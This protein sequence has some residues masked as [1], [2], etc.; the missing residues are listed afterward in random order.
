MHIL[1][2]KVAGRLHLSLPAQCFRW[3]NGEPPL[4]IRDELFGSQKTFGYC[5]VSLHGSNLN[6]PPKG[7][8]FF[9]SREPVFHKYA[10][11]AILEGL[12]C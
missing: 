12:F 8:G 11:A 9:I 3:L 1:R 6:P 7:G 10:P 2:K 4:A 5:P